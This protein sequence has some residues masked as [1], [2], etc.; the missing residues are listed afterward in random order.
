MGEPLCEN[1]GDRD[2]FYLDDPGDSDFEEMNGRDPIPRHR[3]RVVGKGMPRIC[4][5][6]MFWNQK[7][8]KAWICKI[9]TEA[10]GRPQRESMRMF[11][12]LEHQPDQGQYASC[13]KRT[14]AF[15]DVWRDFTQMYDDCT[16]KW[17]HRRRFFEREDDEW[18]SPDLIPHP[19]RYRPWYRYHPWQRDQLPQW[20]SSQSWNQWSEAQPSNQ[21]QWSSSQGRQDEEARWPSRNWE[22]SSTSW[23]RNQDSRWTTGDWNNDRNTQ[24]WRSSSWMINSEKTNIEPPGHRVRKWSTSD[25]NEYQAWLLGRTRDG[26]VC[27]IDNYYSEKDDVADP[28]PER[29]PRDG[30]TVSEA[31]RLH[32]E[33]TDYAAP[34]TDFLGT[35]FDHILV[36]SGSD[37]NIV[38]RKT[39]NRMIF[40]LPPKHR[41]LIQTLNR[42]VT[43]TVETKNGI[44]ECYETVKF[45]IITSTLNGESQIFWYEANVAEGPNGENLPAICGNSFLFPRNAIIV[46][47]E[48]APKVIIPGK[49]ICSIQIGP[50]SQVIPLARTKSGH[51]V[52]PSNTGLGPTQ[53]IELTPSGQHQTITVPT[54]VPVPMQSSQSSS[55]TSE[56]IRPCNKTPDGILKDR[57][58]CIQRPC[59]GVDTER[60]RQ[61]LDKVMYGTRRALVIDD[62]TDVDNILNDLYVDTS[63]VSPSLFF[64]DAGLQHIE[65]QPDDG[66]LWIAAP[67][68]DWPDTTRQYE[69][70]SYLRHAAGKGMKIVILSPRAMMW[71]TSPVQEAMMEAGITQTR[72]DLCALGEKYRK[73]QNQASQ[74]QVSCKGWYLA[75]NCVDENVWCTEQWKCTCGEEVEHVDDWTCHKPDKARSTWARRTY[76]KIV[77]MVYQTLI[78]EVAKRKMQA[79]SVTKEADKMEP[80]TI[81][82]SPLAIGTE[83]TAEASE[84]FAT[85]ADTDIPDSATATATM[86]KIPI[87]EYIGDKFDTKEL[88]P[89]LEHAVQSPHVE[90]SYGPRNAIDVVEFGD[91][92]G[93]LPG[94][95]TRRGL[96]CGGSLHV[97]FYFGGTCDL[98]YVDTQ[99]ALKRYLDACEPLVVIMRPVIDKKNPQCSRAHARFCVEIAQM[100]AAKKRY[101]LIEN[102]YHSS[103]G[104]VASWDETQKIFLMNDDITTTSMDQCETGCNVRGKL[105]QKHTEWSANHLALVAHFENYKC[106]HDS[107]DPDTREFED[108]IWEYTRALCGAI[109]DGV[110]TLKNQIS[111]TAGS[112]LVGPSRAINNDVEVPIAKIIQR[113]TTRERE[114]ARLRDK[115][116]AAHQKVVHGDVTP[117]VSEDAATDQVCGEMTLLQWGGHTAV[118]IY[119][120]YSGRSVTHDMKETVHGETAIGIANA[121]RQSWCQDFEPMK[122]IFCDGNSRIWCPDGL[123]E[124]TDLGTEVRIFPRH[125]HVQ[126]VDRRTALIRMIMA[127]MEHFLRM[128]NKQY[129][130][131]GRLLQEATYIVNMYVAFVPGVEDTLRAE[132]DYREVDQIRAVSTRALESLRDSHPCNRI[133]ALEVVTLNDYRPGDLIDYKMEA[134]GKGGWVG[135]YTTITTDMVNRMVH[136]RDGGTRTSAPL[137]AVRH[138]NLYDVICSIDYHT[139]LRNADTDTLMTY[140][141]Q[142]ASENAEPIL[143]EAT[144]PLPD[145]ALGSLDTTPEKLACLFWKMGVAQFKISNIAAVRAGNGLYQYEPMA[146]MDGSVTA[147]FYDY[148]VPLFKFYVTRDTVVD[149]QKLTHVANPRFIQFLV[150]NGATV[151]TW[152]T[153]STTDEHMVTPDEDTQVDSGSSPYFNASTEPTDSHRENAG[154]AEDPPLSR[155]TAVLGTPEMS[156]EEEDVMSELTIWTAKNRM[157]KPVQYQDH[158]YSPRPMPKVPHGYI[159][160]T[161][162]DPGSCTAQAFGNELPSGIPVKI[163]TGNLYVKCPHLIYPLEN[164]EYGKYIEL[165][166]EQHAADPMMTKAFRAK[167]KTGANGCGGDNVSIRCYQGQNHPT[168]RCITGYLPTLSL[169]D[170][171]A[172]HD[173]IAIGAVKEINAILNCKLFEIVNIRSVSKVMDSRFIAKLENVKLLDGTK[174]VQLRS[175]IVLQGFRDLE[176]CRKGHD[177]HGMDHGNVTSSESIRRRRVKIIMSEC[178]C[179]PNWSVV[180]I[181]LPR[182]L[183]DGYSEEDLTEGNKDVTDTDLCFTLPPG[184]AQY[185]RMCPGFEDYDETCHCLRAV[186]QGLLGPGPTNIVKKL[187]D[188]MRE[189]NRQVGLS[190]TQCDNQ[191]ELKKGL[192]VARHDRNLLVTGSSSE[193]ISYVKRVEGVFGKGTQTL[194][195]WFMMDDIEYCRTNTSTWPDSDVVM[196]QK[197][198][199]RELEVIKHE[200]LRNDATEAQNKDKKANQVL[201]SFFVKLRGELAYAGATQSDLM[202]KMVPLWRIKHPTIS[203]ILQLN[204]IL[205]Q[206]QVAAEDLTFKRMKDS[207][208]CVIYTQSEPLTPLDSARLGP[209]Q[210][211]SIRGVAVSRI[212][213]NP[214]PLTTRHCEATICHDLE[215]YHESHQLDVS[216]RLSESILA[217]SHGFDD[218]IPLVLTMIDMSDG[219]ANESST[220]RGYLQHGNWPVRVTMHVD[221]MATRQAIT[222]GALTTSDRNTLL[223]HECK[224][225][226]AFRTK[227]IHVIRHEVTPSDESEGEQ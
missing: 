66:I 92:C 197:R 91:S 142:R 83:G 13:R 89:L 49:D 82:P 122:M 35:I 27:C 133:R 58:W 99:E 55:S 183:F 104:D 140:L 50:T 116:Y 59:P 15:R 218:A 67:T 163:P 76:A 80:S 52:V 216:D 51:I 121:Y 182:A 14:Q 69:I 226:K 22:W 168:G 114:A 47:N 146:Q 160:F 100:Q 113:N 105:V 2:Q 93:D 174:H 1:G 45:P 162:R 177:P 152:M 123:K 77:I 25:V 198:Y 149:M 227:L 63:G 166:V 136:F 178:A 222:E 106:S 202:A 210:Q 180:K 34:H 111:D 30:P 44:C 135:P 109:V 46:M 203:D 53:S 6:S 79:P 117:S 175:K 19:Q 132:L 223:A 196:K 190:P 155:A 60:L 56:T 201:A 184:A 137:T 191:I 48:V 98:G 54:V 16:R 194:Y 97:T 42:D 40:L 101:F 110:C 165:Y 17:R 134:S 86:A 215:D 73:N 186:E 18:E 170:I 28:I 75:T 62:G 5:E 68:W 64:S 179:T 217:A 169:K 150:K 205:L 139:S 118:H 33:Q 81:D 36:D 153:S 193:V 211:G 161:N 115:E 192:V 125:R 74:N 224:V 207:K 188:I 87:H 41:S 29:L 212:G 127:L 71:K 151:P 221:N 128:K 9:T 12:E 120:L 195:H 21:S 108:D 11:R 148:D 130:P 7:G 85:M 20:D 96:S 156:P 214:Y 10:R 213:T 72:V 3:E 78:L 119:D 158:L 145:F 24:Q 204:D 95:A 70:A 65:A 187:N 131:F 26:V 173:L 37:T 154:E 107:H 88:T 8:P 57:P 32:H 94:I 84:N 38:G 144:S 209:Q 159:M 172:Q 112:N 39:L 102:L 61:M 31:L 181:R 141:Q 189:L 143:I 185:V 176:T 138:T 164:D 124:M 103:L 208:H 126:E 199:L 225:R 90:L 220:V 167:L 4:R 23:D 200:D 43:R 206:T 129:A 219:Y 171:N 157:L 147:Y